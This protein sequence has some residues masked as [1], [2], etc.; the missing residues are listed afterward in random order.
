M[1]YYAIKCE[2]HKDRSVRRALKSQGETVYMAA[3]CSNTTVKTRMYLIKGKRKIENLVRTWIFVRA[4]DDP[5]LFALWHHRIANFKNVKWVLSF[6]GN[7][8]GTKDENIA[9]LRQR[10]AG[11]IAQEARRKAK[12][13]WAMGDKAKLTNGALAGRNGEVR[14][15][16]GQRVRLEVWIMGQF[17]T[18]ETGLQSLE[19]A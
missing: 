2:P 4:P 9:E 19:A 12:R 17:R 14:A 8:M 6:R 15:I 10:V 16:R 7:P 1:T 11:Y 13:R 3:K 5:E 18:V